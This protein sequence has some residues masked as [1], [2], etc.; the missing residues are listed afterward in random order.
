MS[1]ACR[2]LHPPH[3]LTMPNVANL[4]DAA[5]MSPSPPLPLRQT[6]GA[7][8]PVRLG[9]GPR[10]QFTQR[11]RA[12]PAAFVSP[13]GWKSQGVARACSLIGSPYTIER[14]NAVGAVQSVGGSVVVSRQL[15]NGS[16]VSVN[17]RHSIAVAPLAI[18]KSAL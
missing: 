17:D 14:S 7:N 9:H 1:A 5:A 12:M 13:V 6:T 8:L 3:G 11:C 2:S 15:V 4:I 10:L 16:A 18:K